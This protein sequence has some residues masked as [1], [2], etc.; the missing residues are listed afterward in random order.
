MLIGCYYRCPISIEKYD[1]DHPRF[2]VLGQLKEYN[3]LSGHARMKMH[4]LLG[5]TAYYGSLL[6]KTVF[7]ADKL[8]RCAAIR[9]GAVRCKY[10]R[11]IIVEVSR[12]ETQNDPCWYYIKL[13]SGHYR[14]LPETELQIEYTQMDYSPVEQLRQYEFQ[15]P[16]WFINY[17]KVSQNLHLVRNAFY[18]FDVL[19]GSKVYLLPHQISTISR[20]LES[21]PVRYML[22]DEVGLGKTIEACLIL[23]ILM[24]DHPYFRALIITP[25]SLLSQWKSELHV[26]FGI[27]PAKTPVSPGVSFLGMESVN[28]QGAV[29]SSKWD[30]VIVDET[31]RLLNHLSLYRTIQSLSQ[32]TENL[33]LLSAT[34]IQD[35]KDEYRRLL[36]LLSPEYYGSM[37]VQRFS[38]LVR[39]QKRIQQTVNQQLNRLSRYEDYKETIVDKLSDVADSLEDKTF[40]KLISTI[41]LQSADH[42]FQSVSEALS[43]ICKNYQLERRVIRNR[44][45]LIKEKMAQRTLSELPYTPLSS[46]EIYDESGCIQAVLSYLSRNSDDSTQFTAQTAIP[47]LSALFSSPWALEATVKRL[48]IR[49]EVILNRVYDWKLQAEHECSQV[50]QALDVDPDLIK[51]RLLKAVDYLEQ[52]TEVIENSDCK[53]VVFTGFTATLKQFFKILRPRMKM[54]GVKVVAFSCDMDR[55]ALDDSVYAFQNDP[56]CRIIICD[57]TGGEGRNFQNA[58]ILL[59]LDL[60]WEANALEQRIGRLDRLGREPEMPVKS[61]VI[62]AQETVEEQLFLIWKNGMK[63]FD[64]SLS[65]LEIVTGELNQLI[66]DSLAEDYFSGLS[67]ALDDIIETAED[68]RDSV[69]EE[70]LFDLGTTLYR[71][72]SEGV[73]NV[74]EAYNSDSDSIFA[75]AMLSW[76]KQ[77]GLEP[78]KPDSNGLIEFQ[79]R[80]FSPRAAMQSLFIPPNWQYYLNSSIMKRTGR[81]LGTFDRKT[82]ALR[83]DISFFAPGDPVYDSII[84]NAVNCTRGRCTAIGLR[85]DFDYDGLVYFYNVEIP[86]WSL[87]ENDGSLQTLAKYKMYL[88]LNQ[89]VIPVPLTQA[90]K[91]IPAEKVIKSLKS[92]SITRAEHLGRR[93]STRFTSSPLER[94]INA[95][96]P[97]TWSSI[98]SETSAYANKKARAS[99]IEQID[100]KSIRLEMQ[101]ILTGYKAEC[102]Y[103]DREITVV[104]EKLDLYNETLTAIKKATP[105]LDSVCFFKVRIN[106]KF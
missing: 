58:A 14:K 43:Y 30:M 77:A 25:S 62:Y 5:S 34:P 95:T 31:H 76:A 88:P 104:K 42:G 98:V 44:R 79:E 33:L 82:A 32:R 35:R 21:M 22:A 12:P 85:G 11:G 103:F 65:G 100:I 81:I 16:S 75:T 73:Q 15:H 94:F 59:H 45:Q 72:L 84:S 101:R 6:M 39:K 20:C 24:S 55:E 61:V 47:M 83:E 38:E 50:D 60:P 97:E 48:G 2:F 54:Q 10:G 36:A 57:E 23:K 93:S 28:Q 70:Q 19:A 26:K 17:I 52:E 13:S 96:P 90:S 78:E 41:D 99:M 64:Q 40:R 46:D 92:I 63:L 89:I 18:G 71:S 67:N 4:D 56:Y 87:L 69:E 7:K 68:M 29:V 91:R 53:I 49:D 9:G 37:T 80:K 27:D 74:L 1:D 51:G 66:M 3:E 102:L 105:K 8:H 86:V 106:G